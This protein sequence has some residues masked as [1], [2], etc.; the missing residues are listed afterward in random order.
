MNKMKKLI[1]ILLIL[2]TLLVSGCEVDNSNV[3]NGYK[4]TQTTQSSNVKGD[5]SICIEENDYCLTGLEIYN[6][7]GYKV[8]LA[9]EV[10]DCHYELDDC[11]SYSDE[12]KDSSKEDQVCFVT[13]IS[14]HDVCL[15]SHW[16]GADY[17]LFDFAVKC[18]NELIDCID[19]C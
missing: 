4:T 12:Y 5:I 19:D 17:L 13:C 14:F 8:L 7:Q 6:N 9:L 2:S 1:L 18:H 11:I 15:V 16:A 3:S 10:F